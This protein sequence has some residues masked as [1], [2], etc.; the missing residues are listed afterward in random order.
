MIPNTTRAIEQVG[1]AKEGAIQRNADAV[2]ESFI[3]PVYSKTARDIARGLSTATQAAQE[4]GTAVVKYS[5]NSLKDKLKHIFNAESNDGSSKGIRVVAM[6]GGLGAVVLS[7]FKAITG[8]ITDLK[9]DKPDPNRPNFIMRALQ[10]L[11]GA[12]VATGLFNGLT[13]N[14][15]FSFPSMKSALVAI[16]TYFGISSINNVVSGKSVFGKIFG[17]FKIDKPVQDILRAESNGL[18]LAKE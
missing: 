10:M 18:G 6:W 17:L 5:F 9:A 15:K 4:S 12:G 7:T 1:L 16:A 2:P 11:T 13:K 8:F 14:G 3:G